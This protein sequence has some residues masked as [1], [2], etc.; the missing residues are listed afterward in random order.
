[1]VVLG[2][3]EQSA[4]NV[5]LRNSVWVLRVERGP[6]RTGPS[7]AAV[8]GVSPLKDIQK[9]GLPCELDLI[10]CDVDITPSKLILSSPRLVQIRNK[11]ERPSPQ[12]IPRYFTI[13]PRIPDPLNVLSSSHITSFLTTEKMNSNLLSQQLTRENSSDEMPA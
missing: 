10:P 6:I 7:S 8:L 2:L 12:N 9:V 13:C 5:D 4:P 3:T 11:R 1:M